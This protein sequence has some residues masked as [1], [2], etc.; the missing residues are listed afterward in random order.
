MNENDL[1]NP[2]PI[3][4]LEPESIPPLLHPPSKPFSWWLRK[5]FACNP[6]YL[7][8]AALLL[9]GCYKVSIE[10]PLLNTE[11]AR[12][13][14]L[15]TS[16]QLYELLLVLTAIFLSRRQ[17]W[18]DATLLVGLENLLVLVP[19]I[20]ISLTSLTSTGLTQA[21]CAIGVF[22]ALARFGGLKK[23]FRELNLP[24]GL[25]VSGCAIL[26]ANVGLSLAY[27][28]F[29]ETK[30]GVHM[31]YGPAYIMNECAWLLILPAVAA[32]AL[33]LPREK[34]GGNLLPQHC[35]LPSGMLLLWLCGT[36]VHL[37]ALDYVYE[38][39]LRP[40]LFAPVAWALAWMVFLR[41]PVKSLKL[42][43]AL[44][45]PPILATLLAA[46]PTG[47]KYFPVIAG[48]NVVAYG[49]I[50]FFDRTNRLS[51][52]LCLVALLM[53]AGGLPAGWLHFLAP[54]FTRPDLVAAGLAA[55]VI[56]GTAW[57][58]NPKL[59]ILGAITFGIAIEAVFRGHAGAG[60]WAIQGGLVFL[61]LHSLRWNESNLREVNLV[62]T[63][64]A[65]AW[66][67]HSFIWV[68][69]ENGSIWMPF[70]PSLIVLITYAAYHIRLG[71]WDALVLPTTAMVV[72]AS[73]PCS[74]AANAIRST[75]AG[76]LAVAGS[77]LLLGLG[78]L[79]AMTRHLWHKH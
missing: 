26:I 13:S 14:F 62:R 2:P 39:Y 37:Y 53:L 66:V 49:L 28:H 36:G 76:L 46:T 42:K 72:L 30:Y 11:S 15:F 60:A 5:F 4:A 50:A 17:I 16:V 56:L 74:L 19:F 7:A 55:Y 9:F 64:A 71:I 77:F 22:A 52:H 33:F 25:L 18:Y 54:G 61:L 6:F 1:T 34:G 29:A 67:I 45:I 12:L 3:S 20:L 65:V 8:S 32:T 69:A 79:A 31:D 21:M 73:G 48:L 57:L 78:T 58:R 68:N 27:R 70:I 41:V 75:P 59:A 38:Y 44:S 23:L 51:R 40:D 63:V 47:L 35:W 10:A 43:Y 24:V